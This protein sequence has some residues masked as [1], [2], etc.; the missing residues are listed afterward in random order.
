MI[1]TK[2]LRVWEQVSCELH[3]QGVAAIELLCA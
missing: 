3:E 2:L 1:F